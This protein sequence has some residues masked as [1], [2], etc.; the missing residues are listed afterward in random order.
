VLREYIWHGA[1]TSGVPIVLVHGVPETDAIWDEFRAH[2]IGRE[3]ITVSP[4]GFGAPVPEGFGATSDDY[5]AWLTAEL[6]RIDGPIDLLGHD[7]GGGHVFRTVAAHPELVRSWA[8]DLAG[9][10]DPQYVWHDNAQT[11]QTAGAGEDLIAQRLATPPADRAEGYVSRGMSE[12]AAARC[13]EAFDESMGR[14][15][16]AL[17]RSAAQPRMAEWG[18]DVAGL[19]SRPGLVIIPA[20]DAYTGGEALARRTAERTDAQVVL[21]SGLGHWWLCQDPQRAAAA[22]SSF[23]AAA[24]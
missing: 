5:A 16:L 19:R 22:Y 8:I 24:S 3:S 17:Y 18:A 4:P 7:W 12:R 14:C 23:I 10:F 15:I 20:D 1:Y 13:V 11:W 9:C 2:L 6:Q 21:L